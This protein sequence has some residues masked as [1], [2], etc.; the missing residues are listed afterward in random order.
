MET[1]VLMSM[2]TRELAGENALGT[3]HTAPMTTNTSLGCIGPDT[4]DNEGGRLEERHTVPH[5]ESGGPPAQ[6]V[7]SSFSKMSAVGRLIVRLDSIVK[8]AK[9]GPTVR[10]HLSDKLQVTG[11]L[12][13]FQEG[14]MVTHQD[15][16][17]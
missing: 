5:S 16:M 3:I 13:E 10:H 8:A 17:A 9:E 14:S 4:F 11:C 15:A 7:P 1:D 12:L 6:L 2:V